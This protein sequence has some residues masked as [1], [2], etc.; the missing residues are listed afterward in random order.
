MR[1]REIT[2]ADYETLFEIQN[3]EAAHHQAAF[4]TL[5]DR[6]ASDAHLNRILAL[7]SVIL[8][9]V[10]VDGQLVGNIGKWMMGD[11]AELMYWIG[12][13]HE[14]NGYATQALA[15]FLDY[16]TPRP[17]CAHVVADN[18]AS[19]RILEKHGFIKFEEMNSYADARGEEVTEYGYRLD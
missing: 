4:S 3:N 2:E 6:E 18:T 11:D 10:E 13:E 17:L 16:Y 1:L 8:L 5:K 15:L 14:G 7:D 9:G 19:I 12:R